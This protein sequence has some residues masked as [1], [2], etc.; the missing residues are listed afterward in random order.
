MANGNVGGLGK[1]SSSSSRKCVGFGPML[2]RLRELSH[3]VAVSM[4]APCRGRVLKKQCRA[5]KI[6][7]SK[8][9]DS[10]YYPVPKTVPPNLPSDSAPMP[11]MLVKEWT[12]EPDAVRMCGGSTATCQRGATSRCDEQ[13]GQEAFGRQCDGA[14]PGQACRVR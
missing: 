7:L 10:P 14:R 6:R 8:C 13:H 2:S 3:A 4:R 11:R 12:T 5:L 9:G 1:P